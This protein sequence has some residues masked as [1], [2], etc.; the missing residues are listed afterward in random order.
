M[1]YVYRDFSIAGWVALAA[2]LLFAAGVASGQRRCRGVVAWLS[3]AGVAA[4]A[5][6]LVFAAKFYFVVM[7]DNSLDQYFAVARQLFW[8]PCVVFLLGL[9]WGWHLASRVEPLDPTAAGF[10]VIP[11][12]PSAGGR[13]TP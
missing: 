13:E 12:P 3:L 1:W 2:F 10:D 5:A 7:Q 6:A 8:T 11:L 4:V 9:A